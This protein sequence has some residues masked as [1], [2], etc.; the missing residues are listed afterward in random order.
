MLNCFLR[1]CAGFKL[2]IASSGLTFAPLALFTFYA[3]PSKVSTPLLAAMVLAVSAGS[4][5]FSAL[6]LPLCS[7]M[8]AK[9][10]CYFLWKYI[11]SACWWKRATCT[12]KPPSQTQLVNISPGS[13]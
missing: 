11:S 2:R 4:R 8:H 9:W 6:T 3:V 1:I 5:Q 13:T 12:S 10:E 7:S